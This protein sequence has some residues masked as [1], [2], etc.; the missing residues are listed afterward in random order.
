MLSQIHEHAK[1]LYENITKYG[2]LAV[3]DKIAFGIDLPLSPK[4]VKKM[5][6]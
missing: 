5:N 1:K 3:A 6:G 2:T 4:K